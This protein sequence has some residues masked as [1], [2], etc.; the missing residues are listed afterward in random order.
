MSVALAVVIN[1]P[2]LV[3]L[4]RTTVQGL[5]N[6][7]MTNASR[8]AGATPIKTAIH[9]RFPTVLDRETQE[10]TDSMKLHGPSFQAMVWSG[11]ILHPVLMSQALDLHVRSSVI[12]QT[13]SIGTG[14]DARLVS[15]RPTSTVTCEKNGTAVPIIH[16][17]EAD[18]R[19]IPTALMVPNANSVR[20]SH[21]THTPNGSIA[22][23]GVAQDAQDHRAGFLWLLSQSG[24]NPRLI[25]MDGF[26]WPQLVAFGADGSLWIKGWQSKDIVG[27]QIDEDAPVI[28]HFDTSGRF[29]RGFFSFRS[30]SPSMPR[31]RLTDNYGFLVASAAGVAWYQGFPGVPYYEILPNGTTIEYPPVVMDAKERVI[32]LS[33]TDAGQVFLST[34]KYTSARASHI[35]NLYALNRTALR[36][37]SVLVPAQYGDVKYLVGGDGS[38]LIF[39]TIH[40]GV[41]RVFAL[42]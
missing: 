13:P 7:L 17:F 26:F 37:D 14:D 18:G 15:W 38:Q 25:R 5:N 33:T 34:W 22:A 23:V 35:Y 24:E 4:D 36:W 41:N 6:S 21:L 19:D 2:I 9:V 30:L 29:Q 12:T 39:S 8:V 27:R 10:R 11:C 1:I 31:F 16:L 28:R 40:V 32:G 3:P 42:N 20:V